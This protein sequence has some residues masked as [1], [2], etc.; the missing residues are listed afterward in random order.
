MCLLWPQR[1][2]RSD[3]PY[4]FQNK[5]NGTLTSSPSRKQHKKRQHEFDR[6]SL[7]ICHLWAMLAPAE[8]PGRQDP[9]VPGWHRLLQRH[10]SGG[11]PAAAFSLVWPPS[12]P[13]RA[14]CHPLCMFVTVLLRA[15]HGA[16]CLQEVGAALHFRP[17]LPRAD[18]H[19]VEGSQMAL[20]ARARP[21]RGRE[22]PA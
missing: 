17:F 21:Q 18:L 2:H 12:K 14:A 10:P 8:V 13:P 20:D 4:C 15:T 16:S 22:L 1:V 6:A 5:N 19:T 9:T 11:G 3:W 7:K